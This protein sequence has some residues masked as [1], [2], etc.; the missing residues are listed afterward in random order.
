MKER[1]SQRDRVADRH[2]EPVNQRVNAA[3]G[4]CQI[5]HVVLHAICFFALLLYSCYFYG[6]WEGTFFS[7]QWLQSLFHHQ[8]GPVD[9]FAYIALIFWFSCL[10]VS[11]YRFIQRSHDYSVITSRFDLGFAALVFTFIVLRSMNISFPRSGIMILYYFLFS[12]VA[13][14]LAKHAKSTAGNYSHQISG[15]SLVLTFIVVVLL[16]GSWV[17]LFLL[18]QLTSA[19]QSGYAVLK[20]IGKP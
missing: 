8:Y 6:N 19:A 13:I 7:F 9:G 3:V 15:I 18:P 2:R 12:I 5:E 4:Q 14:V 1:V 17:V 16:M 10:W 11:G 20:M